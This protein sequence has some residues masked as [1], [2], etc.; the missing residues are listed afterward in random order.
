MKRK[1]DIYV[2]NHKLKPISIINPNLDAQIQDELNDGSLTP[3]NF[4]SRTMSYIVSYD[5]PNLPVIL[6]VTDLGKFVS[7]GVFL[8][9][10]SS[11]TEAN[12]KSF[13]AG[14]FYNVTQSTYLQDYLEL[15]KLYE[16][17]DNSTASSKLSTGTHYESEFSEPLL[18]VDDM[19]G[20]KRF[21]INVWSTFSIVTKFNSFIDEKIDS[22]R[23]TLELL[24]QILETRQESTSQ[25]GSKK[26]SIKSSSNKSQSGI[27]PEKLNFLISHPLEILLLKKA[28]E[29]LVGSKEN[30]TM[31]SIHSLE[32][33]SKESDL[34]THLKSGY[35]PISQPDV[36][37]EAEISLNKATIIDI[38]A[39]DKVGRVK[40]QVDKLNHIITDTAGNPIPET[41]SIVICRK[42]SVDDNLN[43]SFLILDPNNSDSSL[44]LYTKQVLTILQG[45][46]QIRISALDS[47][48]SYK[49]YEAGKISSET[50]L[51]A[52]KF[53]DCI[54]ISYKLAKQIQNYKN[55]TLSFS[56]SVKDKIF[57][58][59]YA[60]DIVQKITNN[61]VYDTTIDPTLCGNGS[62]ANFLAFPLRGKQLSDESKIDKYYHN[63]MELLIE[64]KN[65][66]P[67]IP[68]GSSSQT[69]YTEAESKLEVDINGVFN[70]YYGASL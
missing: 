39:R 1:F 62:K 16:I 63:E 25:Q 44:F 6:N 56:S 52:Q 10:S 55:E 22:T 26:S 14:L 60:N 23:P 69:Q 59:N 54:D 35:E 57:N 11:N 32:L 41:H 3:T 31:P 58:E 17:Q 67:D 53:R 8:I 15:I 47:S 9:N 64:W 61:K 18:F 50:G 43:Y 65:N 24:N 28:I 38:F 27:N 4:L 70:D 20:I 36:H 30:G 19:T 12:F 45:L 34:Q 2:D 42:E 46:V 33:D 13:C 68:P 48:K 29:H 49:I 5:Q 7:D 40:F 66:K 51:G 21:G 37:I